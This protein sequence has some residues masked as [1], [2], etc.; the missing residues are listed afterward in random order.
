MDK[1]RVLIA[2]DTAE[3]RENIKRLLLFEK[4]MEVVDEATTGEEA[5]KL[6]EHLLPDVILMDINMPGLDGISATEL[7]SS[8]IPQ[9][10][11]IIMSVQRECEYVKK[12]MYV[13]A[14]DFLAKP[15]T[16]QELTDTIR[17]VYSK[18]Q[19]RYRNMTIN[20][21]PAVKVSTESQIITVFSTKGGVGKSTIASNLAV[22]I[23]QQ[24]RKKVALLDLDLQF[25][26]I[27]IMFNILPK[28]TISEI[29]Q[30]TDSLDIDL[31]ESYFVKHSTGISVLPAPTKPE[32]AELV[33]GAHVEKILQVLKENYDY[34]IID[35]PS[36]FDETTLVALDMSTQILLL[37]T[38]EL[39]TIKNV[40][41]S[42]DVLD[43]L[44]LKD[45]VKMV[46]NMSSDDLGIKPTEIERSL[47]CV[48]TS[49]IPSD[50]KTVITSVNKGVPFVTSHIGAKITDALQDLGA[51]VTRLDDGA[52]KRKNKKGLFTK[53]FS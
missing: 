28:H 35:T 30:E 2:D 23:Y 43:S 20:T 38:L 25:G 3:T 6:A 33:S 52:Q 39:P 26:D 41:V 5:V 11:I 8:R 40:K 16:I 10:S 24:T 46:L 7:I 48:L 14:R 1:I 53:I 32:N 17:K 36:L 4:D 37:V 51:R 15:F 44:H 31:L 12:A 42:I 49:N 22:S 13:G 27:A 29:V 45:K 21:D 34:V 50:N 47:N 9:V 19:N 18:E